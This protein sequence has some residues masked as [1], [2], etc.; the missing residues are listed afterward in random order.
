MRE[1]VTQAIKE[2]GSLI[3]PAALLAFIA[4]ESGG[5]GFNGSKLVIQF[6][7]VWFKRRVPYAPSGAW[8][9]NKVDVQSKEWEAFNNAFRINA[10]AA[11]E[12]TS[13]GLPQIMGGHWK[14]LGYASVGAMWDDFKRGELQQI[15]ALITFIETDKKLISALLAKDWH[16]VAYI[17]NG[18]KY[19]E[20]AAQYKREPYDITMAKFYNKYSVTK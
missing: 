19:K 2:S 1:L 9:I 12:S 18:P 5:K 11:M 8:S 6:E 16:N 13:I 3:E 7:P 15:K 10:E 20:I 4:T 14:R 17:F